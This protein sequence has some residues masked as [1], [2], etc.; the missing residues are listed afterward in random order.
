MELVELR[1]LVL[2]AERGSFGAAADALGI[3]R[4]ATTKRIDNL[5]AI[6]GQPLLERSSRGV[7]LTHAGALLCAE[8]REA[9]RHSDHLS[10]F[11]ES[12]RSGGRAD[13]GVRGLL[14][15][16][17]TAAR[18]EHRADVQLAQMH[19]LFERIFE[20]S[21]TALA[22]TRLEDGLILEVNDACCEFVGRAREDLIGKSTIALGIWESLDDRKR[23]EDQV[24]SLG[25][26]ERLMVATRRRD[27]A[28]VHGELSAHA[29]EIGGDLCV[30]SSIVDRTD[31]R[32]AVEARVHYDRWRAVAEFGAEVTDA[33][34]PVT[35]ALELM[36]DELGYSAG[37]LIEPA[38]K[39]T[40]IVSSVGAD[41][42]WAAGSAHLLERPGPRALDSEELAAFGAEWGAIAPVGRSLSV[43]GLADD[44]LQRDPARLAAVARILSSAI[45][46]SDTVEV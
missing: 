39:E 40:R 5:E 28:L 30:L 15:T 43:V 14:G 44:E 42:D 10:R 4:V 31:A 46:P 38:G 36:V 24:R 27:G 7:T 34:H 45:N 35:M 26:C 2:C 33:E 3:S 20:I 12:L 18:V 17:G 25:S 37:A 22:L 8:A 11:V 16:G 32:T 6:V 23:V 29:L 9:L 21:D 13:S 41:R 19:T 1:T